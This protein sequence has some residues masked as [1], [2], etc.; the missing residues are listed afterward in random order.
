MASA[1]AGRALLDIQ[2]QWGPD[3]LFLSETHLNTVK[4]EK[5]RRKVNM[6]HMEVVDSVGASGGVILFWRNPV[7]IQLKDKS[8]NFI[9]VVV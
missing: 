2:K 3:V 6:E 1:A 4:A 7:H 5:V 8:K 9:D